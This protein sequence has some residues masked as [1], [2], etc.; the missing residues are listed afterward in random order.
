[1]TKQRAVHTKE[2]P[3]ERPKLQQL[4]IHRFFFLGRMADIVI[5]LGIG[6]VTGI[7]A[8]AAA[9]GVGNGN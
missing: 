3:R 8:G 9:S 4:F 2:Q 7:A 6:V 1:M 5:Q